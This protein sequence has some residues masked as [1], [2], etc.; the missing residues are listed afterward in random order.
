[1]IM[2]NRLVFTMGLLGVAG[3]ATTTPGSRPHEM[4][5]AQHE[6]AAKNE[7][8]TAAAHAAQYDA[9]A[10]EAREYCRR[11]AT[12]SSR[13]Q[14][15]DICWTSVTNPTEAH[16]KMAEEHRR[17]AAD[18]RAGSAALRDAEARACNGISEDDRDIS[19]F[20]HREDIE[21]VEPLKATLSSAKTGTSAYTVGAVVTIRALP[22]LTP[23]WL[24]RT[25]DCHLARNAAL[26]HNVPEMPDCPLVPNGVEARVS[27]TGS[28]F[29][30][31]IRSD[32]PDTA[33]EVL[34]RAQRLVQGK[35]SASR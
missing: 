27:S 14:V 32:N 35:P 34:A 15:T 20:D 3:C 4:S 31:A 29:A 5:A 6:A 10:T 12:G 2:R 18:H 1:M 21:S 17:H 8:Q 11:G 13:G 16:L 23:E 26:G 28:G 19:P 7:E 25:V 24:Q 22:G 30:V 9:H 33:K